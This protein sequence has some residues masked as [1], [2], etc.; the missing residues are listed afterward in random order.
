VNSG[1]GLHVYWPLAETIDHA[2]W[3]PYAEGLQALCVKHGLHVD[4]TR[5]ADISSVLRTPRTY[6]HK[7]GVIAPVTCDPEFLLQVQPQPLETFATLL[8]A[9]QLG[10]VTTAGFTG[11][12]PGRARA[13][14]AGSVLAD[15]LPAFLLNRPSRATTEDLVNGVD[16]YAPAY[17]A[18]IVNSCGQIA[19]LRDTPATVSEPL[20]R[21]ALGVLAH[22]EDG[23]ALAHEWSAPEWHPAVDEKLE[24]LASFGP[25][26]CEKFASLNPT[27]CASCKYRGGAVKSPIKLGERQGAGVSGPGVAAPG[28]VKAR[29]P[30]VWEHTASGALKK[31]S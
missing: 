29:P 3:K 30:R 23:E 17:A 22:C 31:K 12:P 10:A 19:A 28:E 6:N 11:S 2:T 13:A 8:A 1:Y 18:D 27:I 5:T 7:R 20:W 4:P 16:N 26:T 21:A 25:T 15:Q 24:R 14:K 9:G